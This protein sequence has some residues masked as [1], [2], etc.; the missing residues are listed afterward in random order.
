M[1]LVSL[2]DRTGRAAQGVR[3][4]GLEGDDVLTGVARCTCW[5]PLARH[6]RSGVSGPQM[7]TWASTMNKGFSFRVT[8]RVCRVP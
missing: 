6:G 3:V 2:C 5:W 8:R 1:K 4:I 7:C